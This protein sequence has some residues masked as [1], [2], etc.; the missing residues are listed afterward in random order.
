V[1]KPNHAIRRDA[2]YY[3]MRCVRLEDEVRE[4]TAVIQGYNDSCQEL[5]GRGDQE[6]VACGYRPYFENNGRRCPACPV[7]D[8]IDLPVGK[9]CESAANRGEA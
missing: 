3:Q 8:L 7:H 9:D 6:A 1:R 4:L 5:C 2:N